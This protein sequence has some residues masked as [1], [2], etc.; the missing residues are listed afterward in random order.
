LVGSKTTFATEVTT[1]GAT[2]SAWPRL[3]QIERRLEA[4][5]RAIGALENLHTM[6]GHPPGVAARPT[7]VEVMQEV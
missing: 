6:L 7:Y 5:E 4:L 3:R 1:T 2:S